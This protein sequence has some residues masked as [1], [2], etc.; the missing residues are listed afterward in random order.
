MTTHTLPQLEAEALA[1]VHKLGVP[2]CPRVLVE[3]GRELRLECPDVHKIAGLITQDAT[4]SAAILK[5]VNSAFYGLASKVRSIQQAMAHLGLNRTAYLLAGLLLRN[6]FPSSDRNA[7]ARFWDTSMQLALTAAYFAR[8]LD[9]VDRDEAHTY[10]LFRE[11]GAAVLI[12]KFQDY[13]GVSAQTDDTSGARDTA[14]EKE[15]YGTDHAVIGAVLARDWQLPEEMSEA[16]LW[17]HASF[18][19]E[20]DERP[21]PD[22]SVCLMAVGLLCDR[23][24]AEHARGQANETMDRQTSAA[25]NALKLSQSRFA[26]LQAEAMALLD[27][28][29]VTA[30]PTLRV[31]S[32]SDRCG[33]RV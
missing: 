28:T 32:G 4:S 13:D 30:M 2:P 5:T 14:F 11:V 17:H 31:R 18:V 29:S 21:I 6:A 9:V 24:L 12:C 26:L 3:I 19:L 15:R 16:I 8:K 23:V 20:Q 1:A 7:L 27:D 33:S 25:L 10:G 22:E